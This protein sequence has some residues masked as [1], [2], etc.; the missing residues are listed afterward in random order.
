MK[1]FRVLAICAISVALAPLSTAWAQTYTTVDF[2]GATTTFLIGGPNPEGTSVGQ[3][4]TAGV[5]HGFSVTAAGVFTE[6]DPPG[7]TLT[8]ANFI[9][10]QGVILGQFLDASN[11]THGF[12]LYKGRYSTFDVPG[13]PGSVLSSVNP[14]GEMTGLTCLVD[15]TC[16][17]RGA[18]QLCQRSKPVRY[19]GWRLHR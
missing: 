7:S 5:S 6:F 19:S 9:S 2:P 18:Q 14:A 13:A 3:E 4:I 8:I 10:P 16:E 15:P 17:L 12:V 11:V 1:R